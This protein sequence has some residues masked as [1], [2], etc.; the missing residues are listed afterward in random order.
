MVSTGIHCYIFLR[1]LFC[2]AISVAE[3]DRMLNAKWC[4]W[5]FI[6]YGYKKK[7]H[8]NRLIYGAFLLLLNVSLT[9]IKLFLAERQGF[10]PWEQLPVHRISSA[11]RSTTP[12]SFLSVHWCKS[13]IEFLFEQR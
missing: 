8:R 6:L 7:K 11:A 1:I 13:T 5:G 12:A 4:I 9:V 10:E 3:N 2:V